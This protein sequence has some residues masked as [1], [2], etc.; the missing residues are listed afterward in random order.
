MKTTDADLIQ[1]LGRSELYSEFKQALGASTGLALTLRPVEFWQ[2]AHRGQPHEN[3]FCAM[4]AQTNRGCA[5]CLEAE[6]SAVDEAQ[7]RPATVRCFAGLCHT[8]V[9]VKLGERTIGFLQTGQV[10]LDLLSP[11]RFEA[12][13]RRLTDWGVPMDLNRLEDAYYHSRVFS[14]GQYAGFIRLL[15]IFG[16]QLSALANQMMLQD[17]EAEPPMIRRARAYIAGHHGDP[18]GL[19]E[20]ANAMHVSTFYFCKMFKKA[21]GLTF[22]DYLGRVRVE[23]AKRLL[24]NPHLRVS[25]IAYAVGF[26]SLT[27]FNRMFR[28]LTGE[29]PTRFRD[30]AT[31]PAKSTSR[32]KGMATN[33]S[34]RISAPEGMAAGAMRLAA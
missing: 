25:E 7:D 21:T 27:H 18:I 22:T 5:A 8:V 26:Q 33:L 31:S 23:Q 28:N 24:L 20:V 4:I 12:V 15:E 11:T 19:D 32:A 13:V 16:Q 6:Q 17:A 10:A 3:P 9:P 2:L 1:R 34:A 29:S 14:P 30:N